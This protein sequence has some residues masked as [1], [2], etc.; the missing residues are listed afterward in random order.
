M[1]LLVTADIPQ[2]RLEEAYAAFYYLNSSGL[3]EKEI[4]SDLT[5][6][7]AAFDSSVNADEVRAAL[8]KLVSS[9]DDLKLDWVRADDVR[10][11]P[12]P[13]D[14]VELVKDFWI[15]PPPE[16]AEGITFP[17]GKKMVI[18]PG[19]AFGTGRHESTRLAA[20]LIAKNISGRK[21]LLDVGT[22]SGILA[23]Y[24]G[25][26][27]IP[28]LVAVEIDAES[29]I[30]AG[31]NFE[32]NGLTVPVFDSLEKVEGLFDFVVANIVTPTL[33]EIKQALLARLHPAGVL[34]MS[35]ITHP[36]W[37]VIEKEFGDLKLLQTV[38]EGEWVGCAFQRLEV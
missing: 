38:S 20:T 4:K 16:L 29:R 23:I 12:K 33:V 3:E 10:F 30:N 9:P 14:P 8:D 6:F 13:F 34:I 32:L 28:H 35:G 19:A 27:K 18:R 1:Y 11:K 31:E 2:A 24:A 36:E 25:L 5:R 15:V 22:G 37:P 17:S 26:E 7:H 21:A